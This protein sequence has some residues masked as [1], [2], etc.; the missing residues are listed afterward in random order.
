MTEECEFGMCKHN[1][2]DNGKPY[3]FNGNC[4][5]VTQPEKEGPDMFCKCSSQWGTNQRLYQ[6]LNYMVPEDFDMI[7][8]KK[9]K[10]CREDVAI[11]R[12]DEHCS[13]CRPQYQPPVNF[14]Q[15]YIIFRPISQ[16]ELQ[17]TL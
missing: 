13:N 8:T 3:H 17:A 16:L 14:I 15:N 10:K 5:A 6:D 7:V 9:C 4:W 11:R 1:L 2:D 12:E